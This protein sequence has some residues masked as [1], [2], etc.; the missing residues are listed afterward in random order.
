MSVYVD[1]MMAPFR[2]MKMCHL[3]ADTHDELI[4]MVDAI[5]VARKWIQYPGHPVKEHFDIALGKRALAVK[6]GAVETT[7]RQYGEWAGSKRAAFAPAA[8]PPVGSM[9]RYRYLGDRMTDL[10]LRGALCAAVLRADG[11]CIRGRGSM[12]VRFDGQTHPR[13][14]LA[15]LLRKVAP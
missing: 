4:A 15:R 6:A 1:D 5:G 2:Q 10:A 3:Y 9:R 11:K 14:V 7:W 8:V 12:L 13:V